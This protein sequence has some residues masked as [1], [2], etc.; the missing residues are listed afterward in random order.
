MRVTRM[1]TPSALRSSDRPSAN[2]I[3]RV[4]SVVMF[5]PQFRPTV[6]GAERQAEKLATALAAAGL[7]VTILT[8]RVDAESPQRENASAMTIERF[9]LIDLSRRFPIPG[10]AVLNI[11]Y[12]LWQVARAV[13]PHL[14]GVHVL[15]C[16]LA[17]L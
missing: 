3:E 6:G 16:H 2:A 15:H 5:C 9:R 8:P 13:K 14:Q 10:V 12:M 1:N 4:A 7:P 17:S 11:P